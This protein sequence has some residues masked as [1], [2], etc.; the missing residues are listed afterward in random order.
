MRAL[1]SCGV[2]LFR[3]SPRLGF[4]LLRHSN[5]LDLPKGHT[6]EGEDEMATARRELD[7]ETGYGIDDVIIHTHFRHEVTYHAPYRR[8]GGEL[9]EKTLVVFLARLLVQR[10][11]KVT[12]HQGFQWVDWSPPHRI[13]GQ[14]VDGLLQHVEDHFKAGHS[15]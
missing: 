3:E 5:R 10:D 13:Q 11:P 2:L 12:E 9:V 4:L 15:V 14:T 8:F 7:E 6:E 1:K